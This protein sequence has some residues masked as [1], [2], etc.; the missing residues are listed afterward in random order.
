[1]ILRDS[2]RL[3][4]MTV[5]D[6]RKLARLVTFEG[7]GCR[8]LAEVAG[9]GSHTSISRLIRGTAKSL[10]MDAAIRIAHRLGVSVDDL[11]VPQPSSNSGHG[12][13][14]DGKTS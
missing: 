2:Q 6:S 1:M 7:V 3:A 14:S 13:H 10:D 8:E 9:F 5:K 4:R 11:F 12:D